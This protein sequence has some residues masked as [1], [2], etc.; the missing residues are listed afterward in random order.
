MK[1]IKIQNSNLFLI[2]TDIGG[3]NKYTLGSSKKK[4]RYQMVVVENLVKNE[5]Q[6]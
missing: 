6:I 3:T 4:M 2:E 1:E 5:L